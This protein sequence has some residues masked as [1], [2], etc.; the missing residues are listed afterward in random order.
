MGIGEGPNTSDATVEFIA[1][2]PQD[3][4][5]WFKGSLQEFMIVINTQFTEAP[6][7][8]T[9]E[10]TQKSKADSTVES[11]KVGLIDALNRIEQMRRRTGVSSSA[12]VSTMAGSDVAQDVQPF[13][14]EALQR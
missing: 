12:I 14:K 9:E 8:Y 13:V 6:T 11:V 2:T 4:L 7:P 5:G 10:R 1:K 3:I